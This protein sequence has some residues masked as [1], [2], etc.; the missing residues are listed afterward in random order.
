[1][2]EIYQKYIER[3]WNKLSPQEIEEK[4]IRGLF[5]ACIG[6]SDCFSCPVGKNNNLNIVMFPEGISALNN[7]L[8]IIEENSIFDTKKEIKNH[9]YETVYFLKHLEGVRDNY[10]EQIENIIMGLIEE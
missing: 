9:I 2:E 4:R 1:M 7:L 3:F 5:D 8:A 6:L 10:I